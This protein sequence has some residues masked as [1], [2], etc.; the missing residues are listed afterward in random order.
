M[1]GD[2]QPC[3]VPAFGYAIPV[4]LTRKPHQA[5]I[6]RGV[7]TAVLAGTVGILSSLV[8]GATRPREILYPALISTVFWGGLI[9]ISVYAAH[10]E[11][12]R[13][14]KQTVMYT[15]MLP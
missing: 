14:A 5:A 11:Q 12:E 9:G 2:T 15:Q 7:G 3:P 6:A 13:L 4:G 8:A 1:F 10:K